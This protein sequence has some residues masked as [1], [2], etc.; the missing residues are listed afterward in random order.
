MKYYI[1]LGAGAGDLDPLA[2]YRDGFSEHIKQLNNLNDSK[3][4]VVEANPENIGVLTQSWSNYHNVSIVNKG[5]R[6]N[7]SDITILDF[8]YATEDAP[9]YQVFS[10]AKE[11][12]LK[13]YPNGTIQT[14]KIET[15]TI[16]ELLE[17]TDGHVIELLCIDVEGIDAEIIRD[18][19][20]KKYSPQSISIEW[21]HLGNKFNQVHNKLLANSY[22]LTGYGIDHNKF[23]LMYEKIQLSNSL[24]KLLKMIF[25]GLPLYLRVIT[26]NKRNNLRKFMRHKVAKF[27]K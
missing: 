21:L 3:I 16:N 6:T 1:Q 2:K 26:K 17:E 8:Y 27:L 12:V 24:P 11:H 10:L 15:I 22:I 13:H 5:I 14:K 25:F 19:D 9:H 23:D 7:D 18:I 4:V 20:L